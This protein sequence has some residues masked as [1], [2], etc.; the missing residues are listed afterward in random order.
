MTRY[1]RIGFVCFL[2]VCWN[3]V[4]SSDNV[5]VENVQN[6]EKG[7]SKHNHSG[8]ENINRFF[9]N[10]NTMM[11]YAFIDPITVSYEKVLPNGLKG[12]ISDF[13]SN[14]MTPFYALCALLAGDVKESIKGLGS[15]VGNTLC[16][17]GFFNVTHYKPVYRNLD[18]V[19]SKYGMKQG[20]YLVLPILGPSS[21]RDAV[22]TVLGCFANPLYICTNNIAHRDSVWVYHSAL[23]MVD[24]NKD[25]YKSMNALKKSASDYYVTLKSVYMQR[26][27]KGQTKVEDSMDYSDEF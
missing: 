27:C 13:L 10:F 9:L 25:L 4:M 1:C 21:V 18:D 14:L 7:N 15:F 20:K 6:K 19:F 17:A 16:G 24:T 5:T 23:T 26:T 11:S 8:I 22:A 3:G 2:L 12:R